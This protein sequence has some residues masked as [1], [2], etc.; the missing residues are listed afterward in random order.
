MGLR[1][2][3]LVQLDEVEPL[4]LENLDQPLECLLLLADHDEAAPV[5]D[6]FPDERHEAAQFGAEGDCLELV[7]PR[8]PVRALLQAEDDRPV[9]VRVL[10]LVQ[11]GVVV[12]QRLA[13]ERDRQ[14]VTLHIW[15]AQPHVLVCG[16]ELGLVEE[17]PQLG[18]IGGFGHLLLL[19][20]GGDLLARRVV[21]YL[22]RD[23]VGHMLIDKLPL[24]LMRVGELRSAVSPQQ[25]EYLPHLRRR[26]SQKRA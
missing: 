12:C 9:D 5:G 14:E 17:A 7:D 2:P 11:L 16:M 20:L 3:L 25:R 15:N 8:E 4:L 10:E 6:V 19:M 23:A 22:P 1:R 13:I 21:D 24:V 18:C 26:A